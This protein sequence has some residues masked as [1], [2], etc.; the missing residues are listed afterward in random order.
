MTKSDKRAVE[1]PRLWRV[2]RAFES[3]RNE[4][5]SKLVT[6]AIGESIWPANFGLVEAS[7]LFGCDFQ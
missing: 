3:V 1:M 2:F 7:S 5:H 6:S 4:V